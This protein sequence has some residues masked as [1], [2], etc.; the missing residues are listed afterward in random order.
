MSAAISQFSQAAELRCLW[1][2]RDLPFPLDA[3]DRIYSA[4]LARSLADAGAFVRFAGFPGESATAP[5]DWPIDWLPVDGEKR[6]KYSALLSMRPVQASQHATLP[7]RRLVERQL[8]QR[9]DAVIF[10]SYGSGWALDTYRAHRSQYTNSPPPLLVYISHNHEESVW[11]SMASNAQGSPLTKLTLW[12]NYMK[13]RALEREL[14]QRVDLI[15]TITDEDSRLYMARSPWQHT[16]TLTPGYNG[17]TAPVRVITAQTPRRIV[18]VG[19]FKWLPKQENLRR[20]VEHAD[21]V[22]SQ[23]GIALDVVGEVPQPLRGQ[24]EAKT[25]ATTF[26]GFV[27]NVAEC[28]G[29][30]RMALV[31]E[32]IGGG[33]KLKFLDYLFG[34]V[35]VAALADAAN[36]LPSS[37]RECLLL[38][39]DLSALTDAIVRAVDD[40]DVLNR[41]QRDAFAAAQ[42]E[43]QWSERGRKLYRAIAGR[44]HG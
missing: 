30:A 6:N 35:P 16:L 44:T 12:Q 29:K 23:A 37:V 5:R 11:R 27:A 42:G 8:Q 24:L 25:S 15:T 7:Y 14:A 22:F 26:H 10:D 41:M 13:A 1:I 40:L 18:I 3:G 34:R 43:F 38:R 36:G 17:W 19:S 31:P 32:L 39:D 4:N 20:F 21:P 2:S 28:F 33:F 9:W